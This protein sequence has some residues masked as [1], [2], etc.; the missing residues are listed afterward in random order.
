MDLRQLA[1]NVL[2][3]Q[4]RRIEARYGYCISNLELIRT[5]IFAL[6]I[7]FSGLPYI[8]S[9]ARAALSELS[10]YILQQ[11][12]SSEFGYEYDQYAKY[13]P[14]ELEINVWIELET[15]NGQK[16]N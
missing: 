8:H 6:Y 9:P 4:A 5:K 12:Y 7:A 2:I 11:I 14:S 15:T 10:I 13:I 16:N 1:E 3:A